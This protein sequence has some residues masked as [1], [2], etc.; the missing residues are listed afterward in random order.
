M[1]ILSTAAAAHA[2]ESAARG[3]DGYSYWQADIMTGPVKPSTDTA[4]LHV[5]SVTA[6]M[7]LI[8]A[9]FWWAFTS[10]DFFPADIVRSWHAHS[11]ELLL[12]RASPE[13]NMGMRWHCTSG[14]MLLAGCAIVTGLVLYKAAGKS[15]ACACA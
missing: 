8:V 13:E 2:A 7:G 1:F 10:L 14:A 6:I 4:Y 11:R 9:M 12:L 3:A 5:S 15:L